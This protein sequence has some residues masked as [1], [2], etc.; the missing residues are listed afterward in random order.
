[1]PSCLEF[2]VNQLIVHGDLVSASL[3]RDE[4]NTLNF[5]LEVIEQFVCQAHGL[6]GEVSDCAIDNGYFYQADTPWKIISKLYCF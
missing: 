6:V 4:S 3:G 1:V 5:R 2:G